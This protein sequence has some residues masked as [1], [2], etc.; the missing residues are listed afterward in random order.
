VPARG[1]FAPAADDLYT[2]IDR[3]AMRHLGLEMP[4]RALDSATDRIEPFATRDQI[5]ETAGHMR[6]V[7]DH[8]YFYTGLAF[9][10]VFVQLGLSR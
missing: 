6:T 2:A 10:L 3:I 8:A 1:V 4:R 5:R 7:S 9:G